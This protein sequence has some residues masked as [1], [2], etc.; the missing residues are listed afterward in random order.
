MTVI[1]LHN[2]L[3]LLLMETEKPIVCVKPSLNR[4]PIIAIM[5]TRNWGDVLTDVNIKPKR[6]PVGLREG[7]SGETL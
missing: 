7:T 3:T 6:W 2:L 5:G 1:K 4:P